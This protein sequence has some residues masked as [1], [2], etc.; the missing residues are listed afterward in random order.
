MRQS[1]GLLSSLEGTRKYA[2][3]GEMEE[4]ISNRLIV[5]QCQHIFTH[6]R[7]LL[8]SLCLCDGL[9]LTP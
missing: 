9:R 8:L 5:L 3:K 2:I 4:M 7:I 1:E 6:N